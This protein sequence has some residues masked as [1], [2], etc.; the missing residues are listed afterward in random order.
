[1]EKSRIG[2][3]EQ[4]AAWV[5]VAMAAALGLAVSLSVGLNGSTDGTTRIV[6]LLIAVLLLPGGGEKVRALTAAILPLLP[7][8]TPISDVSVSNE[9]GPDSLDGLGRK[10]WSEALTTNARTLTYGHGRGAHRPP[11]GPTSCT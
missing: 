1:M 10:S 9:A 2:P 6:V 11:C 4:A 3:I 5:Q 8:T 7:W